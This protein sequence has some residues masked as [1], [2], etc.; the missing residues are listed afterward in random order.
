MAELLGI[1][2]WIV[3]FID[4]YSG[5]PIGVRY[6]LCFFP[7]T[8]LLFCIQ[9]MQQFERRSNGMLTYNELYW[10]IFDYPFYV[11]LYLCCMLIYSVI[12]ILLAVYIERVNPGE[13]GVAQ[14]WNYLFKKSY[15]KP[16]TTSQSLEFQEDS[17]PIENRW[18]EVNSREKKKFSPALIIDH[19]TKV[20]LISEGRFFV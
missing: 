5:V 18:I 3:T 14:S 7:N 16:R 2:L 17:S 8:G 10:N 19:L 11:G 9:V 15:W 1:V 12:Y 4:F 20:N 6:L 13:F